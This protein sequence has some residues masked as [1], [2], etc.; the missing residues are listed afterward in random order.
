M[1]SGI[2][3]LIATP[4]TA[5][6]K[7]ALPDGTGISTVE[8]VAPAPTPPT[9]TYTVRP[10]DVLSVIAQSFETS[11]SYLVSE[12][13]LDDPDLIVVGQ[14]LTVPVTGSAPPVPPAPVFH[15]VTMAPASN[16]SPHPSQVTY[17]LPVQAAPRPAETPV[18][19][20]GGCYGLDM[21]NPD[22]AY[23]INHES[24]CDPN[25]RNGQ[26]CGIG[27][28]ANECGLSGAEQASKMSAYVA[29]RYGSWAAAA[30]HEKQFGWY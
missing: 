25:A 9:R 29:Q 24:H 8:V 12:N 18:A 2:A 13:H 10:G 23:V 6:A 27:Q 21:G 28:S 20:S 7:P 11:I 30:Q 26:Y 5:S 15:P 22:V 19:S 1:I 16:V 14:V 17:P 4:T 3:A